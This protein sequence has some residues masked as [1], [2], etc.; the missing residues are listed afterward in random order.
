MDGEISLMM[1]GVFIG[2]AGPQSITQANGAGVLT[3]C[4][5]PCRPTTGGADRENKRGIT[6]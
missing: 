6:Q 2:K 3:V 1:M 4:K 5:R